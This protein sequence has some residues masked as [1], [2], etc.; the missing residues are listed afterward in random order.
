MAETDPN[1]NTNVIGGLLNIADTA[2]KRVLGLYNHQDSY[3]VNM[4]NMKKCNAEQLEACAILVGIKPRDD[5]DN[6]MYQN[7][8]ILRDRIILKIESL[9]QTT[10]DEC[11]QEYRN[12]LQ[13]PP[14]LTC[15]LCMQG[16]HNCDGMKQK[17]EAVAGVQQTPGMVWLCHGCH[18]KN[19]LTLLPPTKPKKKK[20]KR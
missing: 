3:N 18:K 4:K 9:F 11:N 8:D 15:H 10:C 1:H 5:T 7:Q 20:K 12:T 16:S 19:D 17:V 14:L 6:K 2:A 13:D